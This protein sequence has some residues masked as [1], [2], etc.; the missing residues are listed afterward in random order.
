MRMT[1]NR[2]ASGVGRWRLIAVAFATVATLVVA[3]GDSPAVQANQAGFEDTLVASLNAPMDIAW[4]PDG[5]ILVPTKGGQLRVL[6]SETLQSTPAIDL[7]SIMCTNGERAMGGVAVH[8]NFASN[9]Y[10]YLY[11]TFNKNGTCNENEIDGPVNRLSRFV[12]SDTN[13]IDPATEL[14]L[15]D[16]PPLFRD[17]H[18]SG[19][20]EFGNDG[21]L[22]VTVGDGGTR[23]FGWP[24]D[25]GRLLGKI[26]RL[27][28]DG[29]I[30]SGNPHTGSDSARCNVDGVPPAGSPAGTKCQEVFSQGL[31]NPFRFAFDPN[32]SATRFFINDVGQ[33]AWEEISEGPI[34]GADYG[35][36]VREGPCLF[37]T[38]D[39]TASS[40][41]DPVHWYGHGTFGGAATGG[42]FV[43]N[44]VWPAEWDGK[45]L[46]AD[47]VFGKIYSIASGGTECRTCTPP[48]SS[49]IQADFWDAEQVVEMA[50]GPYGS[51]Q[52]L[53]YITRSNDAI[54]RISYT[55][56]ANRAPTA[57][58]LA[59]PT[60]GALPLDVQFDGSTSSD[61]DLETL[62]YEWDFESDGTVDSTLESPL[63]TYTTA[64][65]FVAELTVTDAAG[66]QGVDTMSI[67]PGN[68]APVPTM[69]VP[70]VAA[71]F[72]V[73][74]TIV[75]T[76]SAT[77]IEDGALA[78]SS[79][80]WE[81]RQHHAAHW[82]P[83][84]DPTPGNN[85]P[86]VAPEPEN[87]LSSTNSYIEVLLTATD[88]GGAQTTISRDVMPRKVDVILDTVPSG[89]TLVIDDSPVPTPATVVSWENHDLR[90]N[91]PDQ[92]DSSSDNWVWTSWSD[93]G[94]QSHTATVPATP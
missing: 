4:T 34:A 64:G 55:G 49:M 48:T 80:T 13:I 68:F 19:D 60:A 66:A 84:M 71:T 81:V 17:H 56:A 47:Y 63:H 12:L 74:D 15:F 37:E 45:Y 28:D 67:D 30:P 20:I 41:T 57:V 46:Y 94:S 11:Y 53:Y 72:A 50:F 10:V 90:V 91:A 21:L 42:A 39:C 31:R 77:D 5:R 79:L 24:Q 29:G 26:V 73:G 82:H 54:R 62:T 18:N 33:S 40:Y 65:P 2:G 3:V 22:Y 43:P 61:P 27:T 86:I 8:P 1:V 89:L 35:W 88:S 93:T 52:A 87:L 51:T 83:L 69:T 38:T 59:T 14:V 44:G 9:H 23:R 16:T 70:A 78:D 32:T 36:P 6:V 58:A 25:T 7:G 92:A 85:I 76:G 75:L